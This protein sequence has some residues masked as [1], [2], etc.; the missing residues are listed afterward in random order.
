MKRTYAEHAEL[1]E[2]LVDELQEIDE[3]SDLTEAKHSKKMKKEYAKTEIDLD[4]EEEDEDEDL[5]EGKYSKKMKKEYMDDEEEEDLDETTEE[6]SIASVDKAAD[7]VKKKNELKA[8]GKPDPGGKPAP[9]VNFKEDLDAIISEESDLSEGFR[10]KAGTIFEAA[11][12]SRL[13]AEVDRLEESY[14]EQLSEETEEF[15]SNLVEKVDSYLDYVVEQWMQEN[16][17]AITN[18]LRSEISENFMSGMKKLF[19]ENYV[20]VPD[21]K[22]DLV[23]EMADEIESLEEQLNNSI[24]QSLELKESI[25]QLQ[26]DKVLAE[27]TYDMASTEVE[28][29]E[30][31]VEGLEFDNA[32]SFSMK[33]KTIK[34]AYFNKTVKA[35]IDEANELAGDFIPESTDAMSRY[36]Q[37]IAKF[38]K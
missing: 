29:L 24:N 4:E 27:A 13:K 5:E 16:E 23:D 15:K 6:E 20:E 11:L 3:A 8:K 19:V 21:S 14:Q 1:L 33:V 18:G 34:E 25:N 7:A 36:T 12:N 30:D 31:L 2:E 37:A 17:L 38:N 32:E 28:K 9:K 35:K 22:V 26:R 10:H